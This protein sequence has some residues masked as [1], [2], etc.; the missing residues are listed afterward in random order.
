MDWISVE[1]RLPK[2][3]DP[4]AMRALCVVALD[5]G[6]VA[7]CDFEFDNHFRPGWE[8][9]YSPGWHQH[10]GT[11]THWMPWTRDMIDNPPPHPNKM[12]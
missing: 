1:E 4:K 2:R 12:Q 3:E 7:K 8:G 9:I 11:I 5:N 6:T 10:D